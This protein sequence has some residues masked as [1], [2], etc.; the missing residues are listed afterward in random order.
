[1]RVLSEVAAAGSWGE[2]TG[3][4]P[5]APPPR[6]LL[7]RRECDVVRAVCEGL[8]NREIAQRLAIS[9]QTVRNH[10]SRIYR[11]TKASGRTQL[12]VWAIRQGFW[13]AGPPS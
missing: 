9:E 12:L 3:T 10:L 8:G 4:S 2:R 13:A 7:T 11:R 5:A 1:M 6:V